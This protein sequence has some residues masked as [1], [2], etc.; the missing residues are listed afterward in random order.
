MQALL[1]IGRVTFILLI[2]SGGAVL[3]IRDTDELVLRPIERMVGKVR[4]ISRNPL[5]MV[6]SKDRG[7]VKGK[8]QKQLETRLL[9]NSIVKICN[10]LSVGFGEAGAEVIADNIRSGGDL[11][12]MVPGRR[13]RA[14]FGFCDIRNFTDTTEVLQE[15]VMEF[16]NS[17]ASIVHTE[18]SHHGGAAN[19]NIGDAFLLV[20]KLPQTSCEADDRIKRS[21]IL[22]ARMAAGQELIS[23]SGT[24][25][26]L[27]DAALASFIVIQAALRR[28]KKL[29]NYCK[30]RDL[31]A[32]MP[33]FEVSLGFGLHFG[34]A[35]EGAIGSRHKIDAS[36]LS[37]HV[38]TASRLEAATKQFGVPILLSEAFVKLLSPSVRQ[39]CREIDCVMLKGSLNPIRLYT[40]DVDTRYWVFKH[41]NEMDIRRKTN[42]LNLQNTTDEPE[43][44]SY[45][46]YPYFDEFEEHPDIVSCQRI[47]Q[48]FLD[49]FNKGFRAYKDGRWSEAIQILEEASQ[50]RRADDAEAL[51]DGPSM[52]LIRYMKSFGGKSPASWSGYRELTEK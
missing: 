13:V 21:S 25:T 4:H 48:D 6:H 11:N 23:E 12:P 34:W 46:D 26:H 44:V 18:V 32:R 50:M 17:I 1:D 7:E 39:R 30:R 14:V 5:A 24:V 29:Q 8:S 10:L 28:S 40:F 16:V 35:I 38:N 31:N 33:G 41:S 45:S 37:P 52:T 27:A 15:E 19:K 47:E 9:E 36:Y 43:Y 42:E 2:L 20:W 22:G 3:F 51:G 49:T